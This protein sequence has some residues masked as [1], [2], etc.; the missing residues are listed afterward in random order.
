MSV[1]K[2]RKPV[3]IDGELKN[4]IE[5]DLDELNGDD[6][7][8]AI[9][10]LA[11]NNIMVGI[12]E[13]DQNYHASVFAISAGIAYEDVKRFSAKDYVKV[14]GLVRDFFLEDSEE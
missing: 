10:E 13:M 6:I 7:A 4:E 14:C 1:Y 8:L 3:E 12:A 2:L 9:K 5:Y 11:K